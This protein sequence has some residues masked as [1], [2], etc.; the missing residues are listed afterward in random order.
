MKFDEEG[1]FEMICYLYNEKNK[2][3]FNVTYPKKEEKFIFDILNGDNIETWQADKTSSEIK[4]AIKNKFDGKKITKEI[5]I[6]EDEPAKDYDLFT[7][8]L[9]GLFNTSFQ[10]LYL[11]KIKLLNH[12]GNKSTYEI[13]AT[14]YPDFLKLLDNKID[15]ESL[16][17]TI[18][19]S[20]N[21][22][23]TDFILN[24]LLISRRVL[25]D[26]NFKRVNSININEQ[27]GILNALNISSESKEKVKKELDDWVKTATKNR[28]IVLNL[29]LDDK[30]INIKYKDD[31]K[32]KE[33]FKKLYK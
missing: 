27:Y 20:R 3:A 10:S 18:L 17:L 25:K 6:I 7:K 32:T 9:E 29:N 19:T 21:L 1:K 4:N 13:S 5:T 28:N 26:L 14:I 30:L 2:N 22:K 12:S 24:D 33:T 15:L 23:Q 16:Y 31:F 11:N 8:T